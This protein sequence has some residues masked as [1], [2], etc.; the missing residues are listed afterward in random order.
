MIA[1][2]APE[3]ILEPFAGSVFGLTPGQSTTLASVQHCGVL[4]G[5]ALAAILG[6]ATVRPRFV[7]MQTLMVSGC[8]ASAMALFNLAATGLAAPTG[9]LRTAVFLLGLSNGVYAVAAI[10]S[11]MAL[12]G[13]GRESREGIRMGLWGA[14]QA[15]AFGLGGFVGTL[16]CD[17]VKI[18]LGSPSAAYPTV[19]AGEAVLFLLSA[20]L[21]IRI[22][23]DQKRPAPRRFPGVVEFPIS[24]ASRS[25]S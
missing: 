23:A 20:V 17:F 24:N 13:T 1:Y 21:S 7:S 19:F 25:R 15:I 16:A 11:M 2:S 6:S 12:A 3:L 14:A 8:V 10:G 22:H 9:A 18:L 4:A 5:M